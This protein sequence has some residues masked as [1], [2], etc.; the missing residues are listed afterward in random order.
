LRAFLFVLSKQ[1]SFWLP[2]PTP[3]LLFEI[4]TPFSRRFR[5]E[6]PAVG[7]GTVSGDVNLASTIAAAIAAL[8]YRMQSLR[9]PA[10]RPISQ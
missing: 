6:I 1:F 3:N 2:E 9:F 4:K 10:T 5:K 7:A 8:L